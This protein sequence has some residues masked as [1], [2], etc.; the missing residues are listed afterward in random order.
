M[1]ESIIYTVTQL[2]ASYKWLMKTIQ[3]WYFAYFYCYFTLWTTSALVT[4][5]NRVISIFKSNQIR[6]SNPVNSHCGSA[7]YELTSIHDDEGLIP[8]LTHCVKDQALPVSCG[9]GHICSSE[10]VLLRLWLWRRPAA[11][12]PIR[13]LAWEPPYAAHAALKS[14]KKK[15]KKRKKEKFKTWRV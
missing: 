5:G 3:C 10:P 11:V 4:A 2:L 12:A 8:G 9:V 13:P 6:K 1:F 15:K 7:G 14:K